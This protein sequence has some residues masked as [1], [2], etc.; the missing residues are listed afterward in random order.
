MVEALVEALVWAE[1]SVEDSVEALAGPSVE[2]SV[3]G[4]PRLTPVTM[5]QPLPMW[6]MITH[7]TAAPERPTTPHI[8]HGDG[9]RFLA[10]G[11]CAREVVGRD[12]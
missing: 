11:H 4:G 9:I 7:N 12:G 2:A 6:D 8:A 3:D 1:A 10:L 5:G